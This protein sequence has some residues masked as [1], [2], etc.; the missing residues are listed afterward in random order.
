VHADLIIIGGGEHAG[1]IIEAARTDSRSWRVVGFVG[2]TDNRDLSERFAAPYLGDD[3][4]L[5]AYPT[6]WAIL[7]FGSLPG[8]N[9]R[10]AAHE[11]LNP[12]ISRWA[13]VV[14]AT[15][16][17]S[18]TASVGVGT[19]IMAGA[20]VQTGARVGA[21]VI[22]NSGA[23]VEHDVTLGDHVQVAPGA[24]IGGGAT[25]GRG[26]YIGLGAAVRDHVH[27]GVGAVV[28]MGSAAVKDLPANT[29]LIRDR[30]TRLSSA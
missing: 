28:G 23:V 15:A 17:I 19:V 9:A 13:T 10:L 27:V 30:V 11:R 16:W 18:P 6:A 14:H 25:I 1:V 24:V 20:I 22:V 26:A 29:V 4:A 8:S 7:G 3:D 5:A 21:H 2:P 12:T